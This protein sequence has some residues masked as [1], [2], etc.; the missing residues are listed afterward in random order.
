MI[1]GEAMNLT[2]EIILISDSIIFLLIKGLPST[3]IGSVA[4]SA[5]PTRKAV[6]DNSDA[7]LEA[8]LENLRRA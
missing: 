1:S 3:G 6:L 8:R 2:G 5:G 7:D 4:N